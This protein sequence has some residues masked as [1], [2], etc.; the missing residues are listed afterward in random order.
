MPRTRTKLF[1]LILLWWMI[2][3]GSVFPTAS[4]SFAGNC[5]CYHW[6]DSAGRLCGKRSAEYRRGGLE[7]GYCSP[8]MPGARP[9]TSTNS[10]GGFNPW[11]LF[12]P[13]R[14]AVETQARVN[15]LNTASTAARS[16][17]TAIANADKASL[18]HV[19]QMLLRDAGC[20]SGSIDGE[21]GP[22]SNK[23]AQSYLAGHCGK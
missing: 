12:R 10:G 23:A 22:M 14:E 4:K 9:A 17:Q 2:I 15:A 20:Y 1:L 19:L 3:S 16:T 13:Y 7:P 8:A 6:R 5:D 21:L 18:A 11:L